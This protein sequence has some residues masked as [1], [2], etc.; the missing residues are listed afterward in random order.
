MLPLD[1][2]WVHVPLG[3]NWVRVRVHVCVNAC[4]SVCVCLCACTC[5]HVTSTVIW[6]DN[7]TTQPNIYHSVFITFILI[8]HTSIS[9]CKL[10]LTVLMSRGYGQR[11]V[12][13][14]AV[15]SSPHPQTLLL[16]LILICLHP[17][18]PNTDEHFI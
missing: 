3:V 6:T 14:V 13:G 10:K 2:N 17:V 5:V 16:K 8:N 9:L 1:V 15:P 12:H 18:R 4:V 11:L 7:K